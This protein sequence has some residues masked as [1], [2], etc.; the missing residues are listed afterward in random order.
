MRLRGKQFWHRVPGT[1]LVGRA[2]RSRLRRVLY[3]LGERMDSG[4]LLTKITIWVA[5]ACYAAGAA[6]FAFSR[7][8][9]KRDAA[10]RLAWTVACVALLIHVA[11]AFHFHHGWSHK[12]AYI[13]TARQTGEVVGLYWG[14]GLFI[15]YAIMTGWVVDVGCWWLGGLDS[16]RRRPWPLVAA[17]HGFLIFIIF[18]ATV[19]FKDGFTRWAGLVVC[20]GL[21]LVWWL[22]ARDELTRKA[23]N[24]PLVVTED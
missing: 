6:A 16:Y 4:S 5:I 17:W 14:G 10:A 9:R 7:R 2:V 18:N 3:R 20:L 23:V 19:V 11:C 1:E 8:R 21:C 12:L 22:A 13:E 15:N 24:H